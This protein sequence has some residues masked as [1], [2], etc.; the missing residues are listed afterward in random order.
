[1]VERVIEGLPK[2][3]FITSLDLIEESVYS[4]D[5]LALVVTSKH[6]Y[7]IGETNLEGV[8]EADDL[9]RLLPSI[10]IVSHEKIACL[11]ADDLVRERIR[12][13]LLLHFLEHVK[14][15]D[16]LA[17]D[18]TK[19]FDGCLKLHKLALFFKMS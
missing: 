7:L 2:T 9:A 1:M 15:V 18:V 8:Q 14:Q 16:E 6:Y 12:L 17:V 13:V 10:N 19:Y 5:S 11:K 4:S 3:N